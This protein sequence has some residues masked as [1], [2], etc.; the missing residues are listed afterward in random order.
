MDVF[1]DGRCVLFKHI[2]KVKRLEDFCLDMFALKLDLVPNGYT[3][4]SGY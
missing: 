1:D 4:N 2:Q 3:K